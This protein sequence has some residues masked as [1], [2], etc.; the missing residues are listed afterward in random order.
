MRRWWPI[1][2]LMLLLGALQAKLWLGNSGWGDARELQR[3]VEEQRAENARLQQRN[4]A[5]TAEV[6][7]LKSGET[8]VEERA[9]SELGM[10]KPGETFYR[11]VEPHFAQAP[12]ADAKPQEGAPVEPDAG[13]KP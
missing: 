3:T 8:A 13:A 6:E 10:I 11:V 9:R 1:L 5:L 7:D 4:D 12:P 2:A